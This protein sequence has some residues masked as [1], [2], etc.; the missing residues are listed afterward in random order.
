[1]MHAVASL[2]PDWSSLESVR[3]AHNGFEFTALIF[4]AFLVVFDALAHL[5]EDENKERAKRLEKAGL[6]CFA[7][8]EHMKLRCSHS[9]RIYFEDN[10]RHDS[11]IV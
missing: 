1:M 4:F 6:I 2:L 8:N 10:L 3:R 9:R 5:A 11:Q 7:I